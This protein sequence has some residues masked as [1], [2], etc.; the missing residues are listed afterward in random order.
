MVTVGVHCSTAPAGHS[1]TS[2]VKPAWRLAPLATN[3][4]TL[5][6]VAV[7]PSARSGAGRY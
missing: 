3:D 5:V 6:D 2:S 4:F 7:Q 1:G